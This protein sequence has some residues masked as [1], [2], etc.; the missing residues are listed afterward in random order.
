MAN[1]NENLD[2]TPITYTF[3]PEKVVRYDQRPFTNEMFE[4]K[5]GEWVSAADYDK[6]LALLRSR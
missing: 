4:A 6:L 5:D 3:N 2:L 1:I